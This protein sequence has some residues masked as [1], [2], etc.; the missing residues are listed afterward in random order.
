[1]QINI[2]NQTDNTM[3]Y[4]GAAFYSDDGHVV[5]QA[6]DVSSR[7]SGNGGTLEKA[8]GSDGL[9]GLV[10][11]TCPDPTQMLVIFVT[12]PALTGTLNHCWV[13]TISSSRLYVL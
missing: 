3:K 9:F 8:G 11:Y 5:T 4:L 12:M 2:N 13:C 6:S 7:S 1:M 10:A